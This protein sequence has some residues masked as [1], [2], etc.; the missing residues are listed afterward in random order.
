M[1][2]KRNLIVVALGLVLALNLCA[3]A[4]PRWYKGVT[5]MHSLWSDGDTAPEMIAAW[6]LDHG[7]NFIC[8]SEHHVLQQGD[9]YVSIVPGSRLSPEHV[10][11][12]EKR[13]GKDWVEI[14]ME[15]SKPRMRLKTHE[16]LSRYFN[17]P[18]EFLLIPAEEITSLSGSTHL[19]GINLREPIK[20]ERGE[21]AELIQKY[22]D[23]IKAQREKYGVPMIG[24]L[25]HV[26]FEYGITTEEMMQ[27]RGLSFFEVYNGH[28]AVHSFGVPKKHR[29]SSDR[30]WDVLLSFRMLQPGAEML[31]AVAT[32]DSHEYHEWG[33][34]K[35]NP[36]RGW[37]MVRSE[38]LTAD[39]LITAMEKG[40]FYA[41]TGVKINDFTWDG[42]TYTVHID[43]EPGVT[44]TTEFIGTRKGFDTHS[45]V[46]LGEDGNPFP[47]ASRKYSDSIGT[48][49]FSTTEN[50]AAYTANGDELY[51][52]ARVISSRKMPNPA[53]EGDLEMAWLQPVRPTQP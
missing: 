15:N 38:T 22:L 20:G 21:V 5:H 24:H 36:G 19:N 13:F 17:K 40:Q 12:I 48:V 42:K 16:E 34:G 4:E 11:E 1:F 35:V 43:S 29:P 44:Y 51:I 50:P 41:S 9:K 37:I 46:V 45:E 52:R 8:F 30:H 47:R 28:P 53:E 6:Y 26:N 25:N 18:G 14:K 49:L 10:E 2:Q 3:G 7:Y 39:A 23:A 31:Y 32:D 27:V 33:L